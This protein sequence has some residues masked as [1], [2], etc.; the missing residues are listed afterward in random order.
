MVRKSD[1]S[2]KV[3]IYYRAINE[4]T[5][6]ASFPLPRIGN[7][8]DQLRDATCIMHLDL[9][10]AYNQVKM[11][12]DGPSD[13]SIASTTCQGL[14]PNGSPWKCLLWDLVCAML[15]LRLRVL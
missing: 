15:Q 4:R 8:F 14:A 11:A 2:I 6:K 13:D 12:D 1:G 10:S 5:V 9:R 7:L 3:C